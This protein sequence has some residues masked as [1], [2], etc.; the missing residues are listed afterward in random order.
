[1]PFIFLMQFYLTI[2]SCSAL[3]LCVS[4]VFYIS[5]ALNIAIS[6]FIYLYWNNSFQRKQHTQYRLITGKKIYNSVNYACGLISGVTKKGFRLGA[7]LRELCWRLSS[8]SFSIDVND[9]EVL[10]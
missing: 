8:D 1:M 10:V 3:H 2:L 7:G 5:C 4:M 6:L 9:Q